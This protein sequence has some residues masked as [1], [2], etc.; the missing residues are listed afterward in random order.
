MD[1]IHNCHVHVFTSQAVPDDYLPF[2]LIR[3]LRT[4]CGS[5]IGRLVLR[6]LRPFT[7]RDFFDRLAAFIG[8]GNLPGQKEIFDTLKG[9]YPDGT[10]FVV[11]P[12]DMDHMEAGKAPQS[13]LEQLEEL[14]C[15]KLQYPDFVLPFVAVDPR[16]GGLLDLVKKHIEEHEFAG[17]KL[18]PPLGYFAC[19]PKLNPVYAYAEENQIPVL[20]HC[21]RGGIYF[22]GRITDEM[23]V[24]PRTGCHLQWQ[25]NKDFT[26]HF[27]DPEN[28]KYVLQD[29]PRLK[30]CL[31]HY[32]GASE[33][34]SW[35][36]DPWTGQARVSW[37]SVIS[38][39]IRAHAN[40][41]ADVAYTAYDTRLLPVIK[42]LVNT[43]KLRG[44]ILYG[45]D[46]YMVQRDVTEREFSINL[47]AFLGEKDFHKVAVDNPKAFL[48]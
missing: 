20:T 31:A 27:S 7:S 45:S 17:L 33:W 37:L 28:Y 6:Y 15:L 38:D 41:F 9:S 5:K 32:G 18:Y 8:I 35:L 22:K 24:H 11:L 44:R 42:V 30:L 39:L 1:I 34:I 47:R 46:F 43:P 23:R 25:K 14:R 26:D 3:L 12:V 40:V 21:S 29:F 48:F 13:Y 10:R 36:Q 4:E 19:D 2:K 16:R